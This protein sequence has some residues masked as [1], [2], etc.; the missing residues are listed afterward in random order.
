MTRRLT[1]PLLFLLIAA[2]FPTSAAHAQRQKKL[3]IGDVP[4]AV[5]VEWVHG[6]VESFSEGRNYTIVSGAQRDVLNATN[7][8]AVVNDVIKPF[9]VLFQL[10]LVIVVRG[11]EDTVE[12]VE[13]FVQRL[14]AGVRQHVSIG[15][16]T[17]DKFKRTW[18]QPFSL[19][20]ARTAT[21]VI[22][23]DKR[24]LFAASQSIQRFSSIPN[25][26]SM[27]EGRY[28]ARLFRAAEPT[29][30]SM[31]TARKTRNWRLYDQGLDR[32]LEENKRVF[33]LKTIERF[34]TILV[35]RDDREAAYAYATKLREEHATD[36]T[37]LLSL[38]RFIGESKV[39]TDEQRDYAFATATAKQAQE[40]MSPSDPRPFSVQASIAFR[41]GDVRGAERL[42]RRAFRIAAGALKP[43]YKRELDSYVEVRKQQEAAAGI[44][45]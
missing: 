20:R 18:E 15:V 7:L 16:D 32:L 22:G 30:K 3:A 5:E 8:R 12:D 6:K 29:L 25:L 24:L 2:C 40:S 4:P 17:D 14:D 21:F 44:R 38:A 39:L 31:E 28:D 1:L 41:S 35:D 13:D 34:E 42:A 23:P 33:A 37:M 10:E 26:E 19:E 11:D 45:R 43:Q 27:A 36:P 9:S